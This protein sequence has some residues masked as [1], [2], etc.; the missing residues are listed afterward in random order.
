MSKGRYVDIFVEPDTTA[1]CGYLFRMEEDGLQTSRLV[2]DK[3]KDNMPK[4]EHYKIAFKLH[5]TKGAKL[6]FS[7]MKD[8]VL[9]A[10]E[11]FEPNGD[12]CPPPGS[13]FDGLYVDPATYIQD[14]VLTVIN[15]DM[16]EQFFAFA[17][18]FVPEGTDQEGPG[19][20]Y[21]CFDPIGENRNGG[22]TRS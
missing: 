7:K 9:W 12:E 17:L 11:V 14:R 21:V 22:F 6:Q 8:K 10:T 1:S 3:H 20:Q 15:T 13:S 19:T 4:A 16:H 18:N 2:F 5:N